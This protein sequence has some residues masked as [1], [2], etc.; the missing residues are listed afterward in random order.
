M[1]LQIAGKSVPRAPKENAHEHEWAT[2]FSKYINVLFRSHYNKASKKDRRFTLIHPEDI[3]KIAEYWYTTKPDWVKVVSKRYPADAFDHL[4]NTYN[5]SG[6]NEERQ[7]WMMFL[8]FGFHLEEGP[9]GSEIISKHGG[10]LPP[11][12][13]RDTPILPHWKYFHYPQGIINPKSTQDIKYVWRAI[14]LAVEFNR[15][16]REIGKSLGD[17]PRS[18]SY[19]TGLNIA[20]QYDAMLPSLLFTPDMPGMPDDLASLFAS[21]ETLPAIPHYYEGIDPHATTERTVRGEV[22]HEEERVQKAVDTAVAVE[23][24]AAQKKIDEYK[25]SLEEIKKQLDEQNNELRMAK[26]TTSELAA[27]VG[28]LV[29]RLKEC[30]N[31]AKKRGD[32]DAER[33]AEENREQAN[34]V[35]SDVTILA[36]SVGKATEDNTKAMNATDDVERR[37]S[38][39]ARETTNDLLAQ[40]R[41]GYQLKKIKAVT[42]EQRREVEDDGTLMGALARALKTK[43]EFV[44][45][46]IAPTPSFAPSE[47][48]TSFSGAPLAKYYSSGDRYWRQ[49]IKYVSVDISTL[50]EFCPI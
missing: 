49:P 46:S 45:P 28:D 26:V 8:S 25:R 37:G 38:A 9:T 12:L 22:E 30:E 24:A 27:K 32:P 47:W 18:L 17:L 44:E 42:P 4:W 29:A 15:Y 7:L 33:E 40:I 23:R 14:G 1:N 43:R 50:N 10:R 19:R 3:W 20:A 11:G 48:G 36:S 34:R 31:E 6:D 5:F 41:Q 21:Q 16:R 13:P 39:V 2:Y 35:F